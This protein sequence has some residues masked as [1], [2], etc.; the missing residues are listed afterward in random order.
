[1]PIL[2]TTIRRVFSIT[3][4]AIRSKEQDNWVYGIARVDAM[5]NHPTRG[6]L[7]GLSLP[8]QINREGDVS[9]QQDASFIY[10]L[11]L[12]LR[13]NYHG[14]VPE[15]VRSYKYLDE[16]AKKGQDYQKRIIPIADAKLTGHRLELVE[17]VLKNPY[18]FVGES[19]E[20]LVEL[21]V[22]DLSSNTLGKYFSHFPFA[23]KLAA[24][25]AG[26]F[27]QNTSCKS[28]DI[29]GPSYFVKP[30]KRKVSTFLTPIGGM[31]DWAQELWRKIKRE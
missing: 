5:L 4:R 31:P 27:Y 21:K 1:M 13:F 14:P 16:K 17:E 7:K 15:E 2:R 18:E 22:A 19:I 8:F 12:D 11:D 3:T 23:M 10:S 6:H 25:E 29:Q 24:I 20:S 28:S 26:S 9:F 30:G